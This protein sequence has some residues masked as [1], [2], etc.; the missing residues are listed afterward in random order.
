MSGQSAT[1][2]GRE[3]DSKTSSS[4]AEKQ[5][6]STVCTAS[7]RARRRAGQLTQ[8]GV[9]GGDGVQKKQESR[10]LSSPQPADRRELRLL[11]VR[12]YLLIV[13]M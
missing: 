10:A 1:R 7:E 8:L 11:Y 3:G 12:K 2:S 13:Q 4:D 5:D 6:S 9:D